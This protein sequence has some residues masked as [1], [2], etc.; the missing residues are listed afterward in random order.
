MHIRS[1]ASIS[2]FPRKT[3]SCPKVKSKKFDIPDNAQRLRHKATIVFSKSHSAL[4]S[5]AAL[6][7]SQAVFAADMLLFPLIGDAELSVS[8]ASVHVRESP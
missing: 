4:P 5:G 1:P 8:G 3:I 6:P 2:I 7:F